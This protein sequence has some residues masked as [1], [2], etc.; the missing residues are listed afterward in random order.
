MHMVSSHETYKIVSCTIIQ[1][2]GNIIYIPI[3]IGKVVC[4][5]IFFVVDTDNYDV[6]LRLDFLM[7]IGAV[8]D[9]EK[10]VIHVRNKHGVAIEVLPFNVVNMLQKI[11]RLEEV[12]HVTP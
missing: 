1:T 6:L 11:A 3:T 12:E 5:M 8:V 2:L 7:K 4:Q 10:G 9:V